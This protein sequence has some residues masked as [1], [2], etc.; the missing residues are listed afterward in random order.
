MYIFV[1]HK[2]KT[3]FLARNHLDEVIDIFESIY[4][5]ARNLECS[6][7]CKATKH[8]GGCDG[9]MAVMQRPPRQ[10]HRSYKHINK[11]QRIKSGISQNS[12]TSKTI[13]FK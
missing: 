2:Y 3:D 11:I 8:K 9:H 1:L 7:T 6:I 4:R 5:Q 13:N 10:R 12:P